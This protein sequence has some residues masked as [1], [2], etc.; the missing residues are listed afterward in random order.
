M[1]LNVPALLITGEVEVNGLREKLRDF[2][3]FAFFGIFDEALVAVFRPLA[4]QRVST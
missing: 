2:L 4:G 1:S 3:L